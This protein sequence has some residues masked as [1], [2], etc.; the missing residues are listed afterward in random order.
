MVDMV[1]LALFAS[2][3]AKNCLSRQC[4]MEFLSLVTTLESDDVLRFHSNS[5]SAESGR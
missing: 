4:D 1:K 3:F 2:V 5:K